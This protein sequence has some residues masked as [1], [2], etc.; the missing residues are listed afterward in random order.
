MI[1]V[2]FIIQ[3]TDCV[4]VCLSSPLAPSVLHGRSPRSRRLTPPSRGV[5]GLHPFRNKDYAQSVSLFQG[6][7]QFLR[8]Q[9]AVF[10]LICIIWSS[11]LIFSKKFSRSLRSRDCVGLLSQYP[12]IRN[13]VG[14]CNK[15]LANSSYIF[16]YFWFC[17]H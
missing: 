3:W 15:T 6:E 11:C 5:Y 1:V 4:Y 16:L 9:G 14:L 12:S 7:R 17:C 10:K 8:L 2:I 13:P